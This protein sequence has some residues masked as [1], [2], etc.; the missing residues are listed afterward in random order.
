MSNVEQFLVEAA[1]TAVLIDEVY[2]QNP[3]TVPAG[4]IF[5]P[6][7]TR[8]TRCN[9]GTDL[10]AR[11][12]LVRELTDQMPGDHPAELPAAIVAEGHD[13]VEQFL[14]GDIR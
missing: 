12:L 9:V 3:M 1:V 8:R 10:V 6:H 14:A 13:V 5:S 4:A 7:R 2:L 11:D